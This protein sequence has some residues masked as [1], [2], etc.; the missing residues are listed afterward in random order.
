MAKK[1]SQAP[2]GA[3][4][5]LVTYGDMVTLLLCFFVLMFSY[6]VVA[7]Q[8]KVSNMLGSIRKAFEVER[9]PDPIKGATPPKE[10]DLLPTLQERLKETGAE[11]LNV[12]GVQVLA[13]F[14]NE[15][16][17]FTFQGKPLFE[18]GG[19]ALNEDGEQ[20]L[21]SLGQNFIYGYKNKVEIRG[22][23]SYESEDSLEDSHWR[24]GYARSA[25]AASVLSSATRGGVQ[26]ER[27]RLWSG[28]KQSLISEATTESLGREMNRR[29][30]IVV[31]ELITPTRNS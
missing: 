3:P 29:I 26:E 7:E 31:Y 19:Y 16:V 22:Y 18:Q 15:G 12:N 20:V 1:K 8:S 17:K 9:S 27:L 25:S 10:E 23:T 6:R 28:G 30:E 21:E 11:V 2:A 13:T 5:W 4:D 14:V 24:L